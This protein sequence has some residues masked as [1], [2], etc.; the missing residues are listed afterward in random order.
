M[1]V[2]DDD[3]TP[4]AY[5]R[6]ARRIRE[7]PTAA[8][9]FSRGQLIVTGIYICMIILM[10]L[11]RPLA[12][13]TALVGLCVLF[14]A[15]F[16]ILKLSVSIAGRKHE[17]L[18]RIMQRSDDPTL[19]RYAV[20]L[21]VHKE[22]NMLRHLVAR[23][24]RL[25]YPKDRL[26]VLLLIEHDDLETLEAARAM[27]LRFPGTELTAAQ[28]FPH[29]SVVVVP[30]GGPKTKPNAMNEAMELVL[31]EGCEYLTIYDAE[32]RPDPD[33]LLKAVGTFRLAPANVACLQAELAFWNDDTNWIT[34]LYWIGYKVHF[35]RF[36]PG[37]ARMGLP[38]P[39]GGTSNHFRVS[40]LLDASAGMGGRV[41]DPHN[42]T[43]DA[44]LGVRLVAAG[45][46]IEL[47]RSTTM[48]EAPARLGIVDK[49]QRRWKGGYL[50][51][52]L[53]HTR[54]PV[55]AA[56]RMGFGRWFA[57]NLLMLGTPL[58]FLLNPLFLG[59]TVAYFGTRTDLISD[60]FPATVYYPSL[61]LF[62]L[63][64]F[65]LLYELIETCL[66][67]AD[68]TRGRFSL[69]KFML[70]APVM[71]LWMSRST[72]IAVFELVTGKRGWH[73]TPHGHEV[74]EAEL[75]A[76]GLDPHA[77]IPTLRPAPAPVSAPA[78]NPAS[79]SDAVTAPIPA[80]LP[81]RRRTESV[82][83]PGASP[84]AHDDLSLSSQDYQW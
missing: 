15:L 31:A 43:E 67:E 61:A 49:Q 46:R 18:V 23:I 22:A 17:P 52:G 2:A 75:L 11:I 48:E 25:D 41:W 35:L 53:V 51:T 36:L 14:Y 37:L 39:L 19:P 33:Q 9:L 65:A 7:V 38:L 5:R 73:K 16:G 30:P 55:A 62:V 4:D 56:W 32:D 83:A 1:L 74:D 44:D 78:P 60:L 29:V 76:L 66:E 8:V 68:R 71:W 57:F 69:I 24:D 34:A 59:L 54:H 28:P 12:T 50:Q 81:R 58:S 13:L 26:R 79:V 21:P 3:T 63:G 64:N 6:H 27:G 82:Y 72:Y 40:A 20:L 77:P 70:L 45:Y 42:L 47:L 10:L 80:V 84:T